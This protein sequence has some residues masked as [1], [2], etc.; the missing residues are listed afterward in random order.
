MQTT[1]SRGVAVNAR[2]T[3]SHTLTVS[4]LGSGDSGDYYYKIWNS[5]LPGLELTSR[6]QSLNVTQT[7][8]IWQCL[9]YGVADPSMG[10]AGLPLSPSMDVF[11]YTPDWAAVLDSCQADRTARASSLRE[12]AAASMMEGRLGEYFASFDRNCLELTAENLSYTY[13][14]KEYHYTLYYYDQAGSLVQTIPPAGVQPLSEGQITS[15][16]NGTAIHPYHRLETRYRYN[17]RNQLTWQDSPDGGESRFWYDRAGQLRLSQ[18]AKQATGDLYSYTRYDRQGRVTETGE[19][20]ATES[21][22]ALKAL[23]EDAVFPDCGTYGCGDVTLTA[24]DRM[25][26]PRDPTFAQDY[27]RSRVSWTAMVER[28]AVDTVFTYYSYDPHEGR[29]LR[30]NPFGLF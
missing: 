25:G 14:P 24:Y 22:D 12:L 1:P 23:L 11:V 5:E 16:K 27:L 20:T 19:I 15:V 10:G 13:T 28:D 3:A 9:D 17:S 18:N 30:N 6:L 4:G 26:V 29:P 8:G 21:P 7:G 2:D